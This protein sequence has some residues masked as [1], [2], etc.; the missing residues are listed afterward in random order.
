MSCDCQDGF[1]VYYGY[2]AERY[3][4]T[5]EDGYILTLYRCN[6]KK[7]FVGIKRVVVLLPGISCSSDDFVMLSNSLGNL[8][9]V[10]RLMGRKAMKVNLISNF[11]FVLCS[12]CNGGRW[13]RCLDRKSSR[14]LLLSQKLIPGSRRSIQWFLEFFI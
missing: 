7:P 2:E 11:H 10:L 8:K 12:V 6:S 9:Y 13:V 1:I 14:E 5:T 4:V 3:Q